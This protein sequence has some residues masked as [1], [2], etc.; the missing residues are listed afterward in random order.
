MNLTRT[1]WPDWK[2]HLQKSGFS[3]E[4]ALLLEAIAPLGFLMSQVIYLTGW[5]F[6]SGRPSNS[7]LGISALLEDGN[8]VR[9]FAHYLMEADNDLP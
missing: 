6:P 5:I 3:K 7:I 2:N 4:T 9:N 1:D 8:E